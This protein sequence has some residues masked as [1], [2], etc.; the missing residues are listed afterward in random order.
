MSFKKRSANI[1]ICAMICLNASAGEMIHIV[2]K[3]ES[4][5]IILYKRSLIPIYG[6]KG[7]LSEALDLNPQVKKRKD[8]K[9]FPGEKIKLATQIQKLKYS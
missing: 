9:I 7:S 1:F 5:S 6:K 8:Y 3:G 2:S 4:L